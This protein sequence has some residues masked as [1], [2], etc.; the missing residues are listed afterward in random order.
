MALVKN[1]SKVVFLVL[2]LSFVVLTLLHNEFDILDGEGEVQG[3][4]EIGAIYERVPIGLVAATVVALSLVSMLLKK[5]RDKRGLGGSVFLFV[6]SL[7][8]YGF[9]YL[10]DFFAF[11]Y[12][13][14]KVLFPYFLIYSFCILSSLLVHRETAFKSVD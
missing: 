1:V 10:K 9:L 4:A 2:M 14:G 3:V 12:D 8:I 5:K 6:L 13:P 11:D 7:L